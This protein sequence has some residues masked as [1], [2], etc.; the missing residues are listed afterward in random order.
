MRRL[1]LFPFADWVSEALTDNRERRLEFLRTK[2]F[3][4]CVKGIVVTTSKF[5]KSAK[6]LASTQGNV[7]LWDY[8][9]LY[10]LFKRHLT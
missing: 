10:K 4:G 7:S 5:T 8:P 6:D 1:T 2:A 3:Y 9:V